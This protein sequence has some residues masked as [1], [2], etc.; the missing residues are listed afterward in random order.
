VRWLV[1]GLP[2]GYSLSNSRYGRTWCHSDWLLAPVNASQVKSSHRNLAFE[3]WGS[4]RYGILQCGCWL[5]AVGSVGF[6]LSLGRI[7]CRNLVSCWCCCCYSDWFSW[8]KLYYRKISRE[9]RLESSNTWRQ[10]AKRRLLLLTSYSSGRINSTNT[11]SNN[12]QQ[13]FLLVCTSPQ[14]LLFLVL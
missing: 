3:A 14:L 9:R 6:G 5:S 2:G 13:Y 7:N 11:L 10:W 1:E 4:W 8:L 12:T